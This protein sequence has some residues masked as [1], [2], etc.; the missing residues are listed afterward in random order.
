MLPDRWTGDLRPVWAA[1]EAAWGHPAAEDEILHWLRQ[2]TPGDWARIDEGQRGWRR[3]EQ[4]APA[5][6]STTLAHGWRSFSANGYEREDAVRALEHDPHETAFGF[7]LV[8]CDDWVSAVR[9]RA[10]TAVVARAAEGKL[11]IAGWMPLLLARHAR[12]RADGLIEACEAVSPPGLAESVL[13]HRDRNTRRWALRRVL[14]RDPDANALRLLL[15]SVHDSVVARILATHLAARALDDDLRA[16]MVD[17][18]AG[19]R[20]A[21]WGEIAGGR[22]PELDLGP[23]LM[24]S[25]GSIRV[26]AQRTARTRRFDAGAIYLTSPQG[27]PNERRRRLVALGEWGAGEAVSIAQTCLADRDP[28]VRV[29]AIT[30]LA[31]RMELPESLLLALLRSRRGPELRAVRRGLEQNRVRVGDDDLAFLRGGD[32]EQRVEAWRLGRVRGRW[33][34]LLA[35]LQAIGDPHETLAAAANTD[36]GF[37]CRRVAPEAGRPNPEL[38]GKLDAA[39][40]E[41]PDGARR[42]FVAFVLRT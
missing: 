38:R 11:D 8:R 14:A 18:R 5:G 30:V 35:D 1:L 39:L 16:L 26:L 7:L 34:R 33:E 25:A 4:C 36:L 41:T 19:V 15:A 28:S 12:A 32:A 21:A 29:A 23:G 40:A 9:L 10:R 13:N 6:A 3:S 17:R 27:T 37:W 31:L 2:R 22:L 20:R 42:G 24:D